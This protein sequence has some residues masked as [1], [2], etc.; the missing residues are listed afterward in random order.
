[1]SNR[2]V[3]EE[4]PKENEPF[5][6]RVM[7]D[8]L[9]SKCYDNT[10]K[11]LDNIITLCNN[12]WEQTR[13]FEKHNQRLTEEN[14][15]LRVLLKEAEDEIKTLKQNNKGLMESLVEHESED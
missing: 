11:G 12:L 3:L 1:M 7:I 10:L 8:T 6:Y 14:E 13:R 15:Q 2:F 9:T 5:L 4:R